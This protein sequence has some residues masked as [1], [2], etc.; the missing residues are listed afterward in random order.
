MKRMTLFALTLL[1]FSSISL[2]TALAQVT[3]EHGEEVTAVAFS[4]DGAL[5]ASAGTGQSGIRYG[6]IVKLWDVDTPTNIPIVFYG[7]FRNLKSMAFSP[8]GTILAAGSDDLTIKLWNMA[9]GE[10]IT[11]LEGT[12]GPVT[13]IAFSP[14]GTLL[15]SA[16]NIRGIV[17]L[18]D[19]VKGELITTLE[20]H[21]RQ[22]TSVAF[23]PDGTLLASASRDETIRLWDMATPTK[24]PIVLGEEVEF[25]SFGFTSVAFSPDGTTLSAG[26]RRGGYIMLWD[27][28]KGEL[29]T[30]LEGDALE[31]TSI[32]FSP[33][34]T[35]LASASR[36]IEL[37]DVVKGELIT[38][39]EGHRGDISVAF[40]PDG[41]TL[42]SGGG[43]F[44]GTVKLWELEPILQ[45]AA[46][47]GPPKMHNNDVTSVAFS[48]DGT[49]L[50]SAS[51]DTTIKL[52]DVVTSTNA[53]IVLGGGGFDL[54][55][56]AFSPDG[57]ILAAGSEDNT[58]KLWDVATRE[59]IATLFG[60]GNGEV[61]SVAFSPDGAILAVARDNN[62]IELWDASTRTNA[63]LDVITRESIAIL[64]EYQRN[65]DVTSVAF[66]PDGTILASAYS[67]NTVKLWAVAT[68]T[69]IAIL[70]GHT[71]EVTSVAFS[72]NGILASGSLDSTVKLW[73]VVKEEIIMTVE[74]HTRGVT[75]VS[76]SPDGTILASGS[77]DKTVKLWNVAKREL[78]TTLEGHKGEVT[79]I[80]FSPD[81]TTLASGG[82]SFDD[83]VKLWDL[84]LSVDSTQEVEPS[85]VVEDVNGD[86]TVNI[87]DL[88]LVAS[89]LGQ[90]GENKADVNGDGVVDIRD[91][92]KVA[93][94]LGNNAAAPSLHPQA[95]EILTATNIKVWLSQAQSLDL[96]DATSQRGI[97]FLEQLLTMLIPKETALLANYPNPF[98]P[99]TW[100]PYQLSKPAEVTITIYAV[101]GQVVRTLSLGH[102]LAGIYQTRSRATYWDGKNEL[103]ESVA[104][105]LY[106][107]TFTAGDFSATR[108]M[109]IRK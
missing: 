33:D 38:T 80:A 9:E 21:T 97:L 22:V 30:T 42:A 86:E 106:F 74:G 45:S 32:A 2:Q 56:V 83:T 51:K 34:G 75:S 82:G 28:A 67:D 47:Q 73:D 19:V 43:T 69:N 89:N 14:D 84:T 60:D 104:S 41:K 13:S 10:L 79:S 78:I 20:G 11:T 66:S 48:P 99:E 81:G 49:L 101:N 103:G 91:L 12:G 61:N 46:M 72:P 70:E 55:A 15:A 24:T 44:D 59:L 37:W 36:T 53:P 92:V 3:L 50:A 5:L 96:T 23:S 58:F 71:V 109:L 87:Q 88:V 100:I 108:K 77:G 62:R 52:W 40:S 102:Q 4:P 93:G 6:G 85:P 29:I 94:A 105:G 76:F 64:G 26:S 57:T 68:H 39:L 17:A 65:L 7:G 8:D 95:L 1:V 98:N 31:V 54:N 25:V 63:E 107:Y 35:I 90:T 16:S 18:W 27:V